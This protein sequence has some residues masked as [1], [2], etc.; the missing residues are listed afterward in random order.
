M[1]FMTR[2]VKCII[3]NKTDFELIAT[4]SEL[5]IKLEHGTDGPA[6]MCPIPA[7]GTAEFT[8]STSGLMT[9]TEGFVVYEIAKTQIVV[10][11]YWKNPFVGDN[12]VS[13][14]PNPAC[15]GHA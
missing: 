7:N 4:G 5:N 11:L 9:G 6:P 3:V 13:L 2:S 12:E 10:Q 15:R 14:R 8:T 1:A